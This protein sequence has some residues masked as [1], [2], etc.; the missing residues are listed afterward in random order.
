MQVKFTRF[1]TL[2]LYFLFCIYRIPVY[3][4]FYCI[5]IYFSFSTR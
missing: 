2:G 5:T 3:T 1:P 4:G